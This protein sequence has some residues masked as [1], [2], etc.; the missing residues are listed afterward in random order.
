MI[1]GSAGPLLVDLRVFD[2]YEGK[3]IPEGHRSVAFRLRYQSDETNPDRRGRG[4]V[5]RRLLP[6][7]SGRSLVSNRERKGRRGRPPRCRPS[8]NWKTSSIR[9]VS[10]VEGA[11]GGSSKR[12][13]TE[14]REMK[15]LLRQ[16]T[17]GEEDPARC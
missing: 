12:P 3:G 9:A 6:I 15:E 17:E 2:L 10:P 8:T 1:R 7:V 4:A 11:P 16:F 13:R 14:G 5:R